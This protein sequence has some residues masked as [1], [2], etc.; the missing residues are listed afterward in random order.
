MANES[1]SPLAFVG[2]YSA[3]VHV[4]WRGLPLFTAR[5]GARVRRRS[6][7]NSVSRQLAAKQRAIFGSKGPGGPWWLK[8]KP[9][10]K[11]SPQKRKRTRNPPRQASR[12]YTMSSPKNQNWFQKR[13]QD[14]VH[15]IRNDWLQGS[16][17][18]I[19]LI[20]R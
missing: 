6:C 2:K 12:I 20:T 5:S 11:T 10:F 19:T 18:E 7:G 17:T 14:L 9:R 13:C 16:T 3:V 15:R 1:A 4:T 8:G